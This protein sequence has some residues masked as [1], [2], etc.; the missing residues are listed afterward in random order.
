MSGHLQQEAN[1][2]PLQK[3]NIDEYFLLER[4]ACD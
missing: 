4:V 1:D 2:T 3:F